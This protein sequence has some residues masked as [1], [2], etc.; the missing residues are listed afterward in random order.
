MSF[1]GNEYQFKAIARAIVLYCRSHHSFTH[2]DIEQILLPIAGDLDLGLEKTTQ[3]L[4]A[5][6][7]EAP[8]R[9][10]SIAAAQQALAQASAGRTYPRLR[11]TSWARLTSERSSILPTFLRQLSS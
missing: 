11:K 9:A 6:L 4:F 10:V 3:A 1:L 5:L 8:H 7:S 2:S